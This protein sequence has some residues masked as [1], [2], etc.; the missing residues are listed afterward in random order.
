LR[1]RYKA[2]LGAGVSTNKRRVLGAAIA[3]VGA[4]LFVSALVEAT[5]QSV[6]TTVKIEVH[7]DRSQ[8][9]WR[10]IWNFWGY[11]EPN[12]T[13]AANGKK[14][15]REFAQMSQEP[16]YIRVHNLFTTGDGS[17]ALKWGSTNVYT[18]DA[19]GKPVYDWKIVDRIFDTF[20]ETGVKPL[21][22]LGFM[23]E[24]MS[25]H[26]DPYR[27]TFPKGN[28]F[29]GWTY[30]PKDYAKWGELVFRFAQHLRERYGDDEVKSWLW[31]V[32]NEPDIDYWHGTPEEYF[33]LYDFSV[34]AVLRAVPQ[35][36]IGGP[37]STGPGSPKAIAFLHD[38]LE[39]CARG[40][41]SANGKTGT[42]LDFVSFHPKGSPKWLGDHVQMGISKQLAAV[43]QGFSI[44][45]S[46]PEWKSTPVI[47]GESDPEGCAAC[48][49]Q[50]NPQN[51]YRNGPL[52]ASYTAEVFSRI[53][54]LAA[55]R[56][57]QMRAAVNWSFEFEDQ[58]PF[59]GF[60]EM[61][62]NGI[63]KP[64]LN[65]FRMMGLLGGERIEVQSSA[66]LST[67]DV[68]KSGVRSQADISA[69]ATRKPNEIGV[70]AW[71]YHD[72]DAAAPPAP[73]DLKV[74]GLPTTAKRVLVEHFRIDA[75]RSNAF[76]VWK[77]MGSPAQPSAEQF[78][79]LEAAGQLQLL[80]S[81]EWVTAANGAL[82]LKFDLPRQAVSLVRVTW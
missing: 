50:D 30:P 82:T 63:D 20:R 9:A 68:L 29:T 61:A 71:N 45:A 66:A 25:T 42:R 73:V 22:Q 60:R 38:F 28:I 78:R 70:L 52:Y 65:T 56:R 33:K 14:L 5:A 59:A 35:A 12:F 18:E 49:A 31:E 1:I 8:G 58:P 53:Q 23:P 2:S 72:D 44:V 15:L 40:K 74:D 26:P 16:V 21:V 57:V 17:A 7:A 76:E 51:G 10:N 3:I 81:P 32:W 37:D 27:H 47:L 62:T 36:H 19:A 80:A 46:F 6:A 41:N 34:D 77:A 64:V 75:T 43:D 4:F 48:S 67:D 69:V 79:T 54:A 24:A 55:Q 13:Y 39:H 11:D